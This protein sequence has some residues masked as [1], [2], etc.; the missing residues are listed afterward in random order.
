MKT[1]D[2]FRECNVN[3]HAISGGHLCR[4]GRQGDRRGFVIRD[5]DRK[6]NLRRSIARTVCCVHR[7][8]GHPKRENMRSGQNGT[9]CTIG[10]GRC[11]AAVIGD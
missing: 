4:I 2:W 3:D 5:G 10:N 8:R 11:G 6:A 7:H 1:R 9:A